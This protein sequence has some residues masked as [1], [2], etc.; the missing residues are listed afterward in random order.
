MTEQLVTGWVQSIYYGIAIRAGDSKPQPG[1][2]RY[3]KHRR[4]IQI[5]V[6]LA[7]L[8]YTII[9]ADYDI[10]RD[11]SFYQDL[12]L[13]PDVDDRA[14]KSRF[15]KLYVSDHWLIAREDGNRS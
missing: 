15:R 5:V 13:A 4:R 11:G 8:L 6:V 9:Q 14:I 7:Y 12:G 3:W 1:S 10:Q 2:P